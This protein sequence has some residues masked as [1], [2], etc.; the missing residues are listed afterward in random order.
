VA[1]FA[2]I[3]LA[4]FSIG[5]PIM[6]FYMLYNRRHKLHYTPRQQKWLNLQQEK[7]DKD[8]DGETKDDGDDRQKTKTTEED[9][10]ETRAAMLASS[11]LGEKSKKLLLAGL[12]SLA[13]DQESTAAITDDDAPSEKRIQQVETTRKRYGILYFTYRPE[14]YVHT[15]IRRGK[16]LDEKFYVDRPLTARSSNVTTVRVCGGALLL[17]L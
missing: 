6:F 8:Q 15:T 17:L 7:K 9:F 12:A 13:S 14:M 16:P 3:V 2:G 10:E 5:V 4:L 11:K 1:V